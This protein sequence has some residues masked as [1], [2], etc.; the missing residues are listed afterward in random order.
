VGSEN[1][2]NVQQHHAIIASEAPESPYFNGAQLW[3]PMGGRIVYA[4]LRYSL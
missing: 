4:G 2:S 3:A 1:L